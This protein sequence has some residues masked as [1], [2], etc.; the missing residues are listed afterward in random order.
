MLSSLR[1]FPPRYKYQLLGFNY[2]GGSFFGSNKKVGRT[3]V[4]LSVVCIVGGSLV[5]FI[6]RWQMGTL[7]G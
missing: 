6:F 1:G 2:I 5:E 7:V 4:L 3:L